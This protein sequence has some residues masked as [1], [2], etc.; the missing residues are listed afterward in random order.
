MPFDYK[1]EKIANYTK[2]IE[3]L[4]VAASYIKLNGAFIQRKQIQINQ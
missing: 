4:Q 3:L 2:I 1:F